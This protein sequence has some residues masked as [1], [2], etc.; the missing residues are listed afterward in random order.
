MTRMKP[1]H[2]SCRGLVQESKLQS[3]LCI[4][5]TVKLQGH[6]CGTIK[7]GIKAAWFFKTAKDFLG[8]HRWLSLVLS[9]AWGSAKAHPQEA[10]AEKRITPTLRTQASTLLLPTGRPNPLGRGL[11]HAGCYHTEPQE[12]QSWLSLSF[13]QGTHRMPLQTHDMLSLQNNHKHPE[14][15]SRPMEK[16]K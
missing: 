13:Q 2:D 11:N 3:T 1:F 12:E 15:K 14:C 6:F 16:C 8:R 9:A 4:K 7:V 5:F 10:P